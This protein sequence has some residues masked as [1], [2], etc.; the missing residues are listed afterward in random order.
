MKRFYLWLGLAALSSLLLVVACGPSTVQ[1]TANQE[2]TA[3][4]RAI[5]RQQDIEA[6]VQATL[7]ANAPTPTPQSTPVPSPAPASTRAAAQIS[8]PDDVPRITAQELK[9]LLDANQ[10][11]V[12]DARRQESFAQKHI[13]EA[14][15]LPQNQVAARLDELPADKLAIFYCT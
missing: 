10:A 8:S 14:I 2:T 7:T 11:V 3:T 12:F 1:P 6:A 5:V 15:S 13:I 9:T 4:E